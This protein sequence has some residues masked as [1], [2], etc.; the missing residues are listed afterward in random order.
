MKKARKTLLW[1]GM[2]CALLL[3]ACE[4]PHPELSISLDSDY[5]KVIEAIR[6]SN[7]SL[8]DNLALIEAAV[9]DGM[10][11]SEAAM[12]LIETAV[13][14]LNGSMSDKLA[15][16]EAA[17]NA[18]TASLETKL[19]L[20]E[21]AV[22]AGFA[23]SQAQQELL[24]A[25]IESMGGSLEDK[26]AAIEEAIGSQATSLAAKLGLIEAAVQSGFA[27]VATAEELLQEVIDS[28]GET[29]GEKIAAIE[30]AVGSQTTSLAAKLALIETAVQQGFAE[31]A[32]SQELIKTAIDSLRGSME[33]KM[34]ALSAAMESQTVS[35]ETKLDAVAEA[36]KGGSVASD[37]ALDLIRKAIESMNGNLSSKL[38]AIE[39]AVADQTKS[40][41]TKLDL[42]EAA[43]SSGVTDIKK[44]QDL[45]KQ[46]IDGVGTSVSEKLAAIEQAVTSQ[47]TSLAA[48]LGLIETAVK[49]GLADDKKELE[50]ITKALNTLD[51]DAKDKLAAI[52]RAITSQTSGLDTKLGTISQALTDGFTSESQALGLI[53]QAL[54]TLKDSV[55]GVDKDLKEKIDGVIEAIG[56]ISTAMTGDLSSKLSQIFS[57]VQG[58]KDYSEILDAIKT[59]IENLD[60]GGGGSGGGGGDS[61]EVEF[62][63]DEKVPFTIPI[64]GEIDL[65][66]SMKNA[67]ALTQDMVEIDQLAST[68]FLPEKPRTK[69]SANDSVR[70]FVKSLEADPSVEGQ[71]L[72]TISSSCPSVVWDESTLALRFTFPVEGG[73]TESVTS[74]SFQTIVTP[75]A[76]DAMNIWC[77]PDA[78]FYLFNT[79]EE[80]NNYPGGGHYEG[81]AW[82]SSNYLALD[83]R[84]FTS[85]KSETRTYSA[86]DIDSVCF[87][88][89]NDSVA[90]VFVALDKNKGYISFTPDTAGTTYHQYFPTKDPTDPGG[91]RLWKNFLDS[92]G[93]KHE[94]LQGKLILMDRW[95]NQDTINKFYLSWYNS[96]WYP[97][98]PMSLSSN[99]D[100][101]EKAG[102]HIASLN[103]NNML[104]Q[105][106]GLNAS[107]LKG[108]PADRYKLEDQYDFKGSGDILAK[109]ILDDSDPDEP[110]QMKLE[111]IVGNLN[112]GDKY[113]IHSVVDLWV[114]PSETD[115][116]FVLL[117]RFSYDLEIRITD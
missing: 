11:D 85:D 60:L 52:E 113:F 108:L 76:R 29:L 45:I 44:A 3:S 19:A 101:T 13:A 107:G 14:S 7:Q 110:A 111:L 81:K 114:K 97:S 28:L 58:I 40:L 78:T 73:G 115:P 94:T 69:A 92:S 79:V 74:P 116:D 12:K 109:L 36:A 72:V 62:R 63:F 70:F 100:F 30:K 86:A 105:K 22:T 17:V 15:A 67:P 9:R 106:L 49:N 51:G 88:P 55:D 103:L 77:Y 65:P 34:A 1:G 4:N 87:V 96:T 24:Q 93:V 95:N 41:E 39:K 84:K 71:Y 42:I 66:L 2:L 31:Q 89:A 5:S 21:A 33:D 18:Q 64:G 43:V 8:A 6:Q 23:D 20:I 112:S 104:D 38:S 99:R 98:N 16:I 37:E 48:K 61:A 82:M 47:T 90:P 57:A 56:K 117:K 75:R 91:H 26:L 59:A 27:D 46:A 54:G 32:A 83:S 35:L 53:K 50:L 25:A 10:A 68:L 102:K 80:L